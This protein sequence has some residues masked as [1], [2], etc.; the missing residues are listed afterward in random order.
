VHRNPPI[1]IQVRPC[2]ARLLAAPAMPTGDKDRGK[3]TYYYAAHRTKQDVRL[4]ASGFHLGSL[5][6][7]R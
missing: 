1:F 5:T 7:K 2:P 3:E 4:S 6:A